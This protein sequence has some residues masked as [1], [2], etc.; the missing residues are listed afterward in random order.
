MTSTPLV[1]RPSIG[2]E[3][4]RWSQSLRDR[5]HV[6]IRPITTKDEAAERA[7]MQGLS[8]RA[9]RFGFLGEAE[10]PG[11]PTG[12]TCVEE[13]RGHDVAFAA[14]TMDDSRERMVG[15]ARYST[16][17]SSQHCECTV[18]VDEEWQGK[19]LGT[20]LMRHLIEV[21]RIRGIRRMTS[22]ASAENVQM[23]DLAEHLGFQARVD[24]QDPSR[25]I[26]A[27]SL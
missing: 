20:V 14:F 18:T 9:R 24:P 13:G 4:P 8:D 10:G 21:A 3:Y 15:V 1:Q 27:L 17:D 7:F 23:H 16:D 12:E 25:V 5:S 11:E 22:T 26:Y 6:L 19:G 2:P